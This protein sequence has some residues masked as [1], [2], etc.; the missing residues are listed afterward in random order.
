MKS[1]YENI[2]KTI[3]ITMKIQLSQRIFF[4]AVFVHIYLIILRGAI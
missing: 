3:N 2:Y 4:S 1:A